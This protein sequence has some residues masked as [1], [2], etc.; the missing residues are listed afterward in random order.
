M[1]YIMGNNNNKNTEKV[2]FVGAYVADPTLV[3]D[4]PKNKING[5]SIL[6]CDNC[7]DF[8]YKALY[9]SIIDE[10]NMAPNT[11]RGKVLFPEQLDPKENRFNNATFDRS[12]WFIEDLNSGDYL[13]F[14]QRYLNLAS[15]EEMF[16]DI[17]EF[18][19]TV[20]LPSKRLKSFDAISGKRIMLRMISKN[21]K[22]EM[23]SFIDKSK[24]DGKREM[25]K[26][27]ERMPDI[28][29]FNN[30]DNGAASS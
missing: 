4:K 21:Q 16:D 25:V 15:Y 24:N 22:R 19:T 11:Q 30:K 1:G 3:S 8:D 5:S 29:G 6:I 23:V 27:I 13:N 9:P 26:L 7:N 2:G 14:C 17:E 12:V 18:F 20:K 28:N 10:N